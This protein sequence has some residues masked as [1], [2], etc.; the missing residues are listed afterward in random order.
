MSRNNVLIVTDCEADND[1]L[2]ELHPAVPP[3]LFPKVHP[4]QS[5]N[6][7]TRMPNDS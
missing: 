7:G 2:V 3:T 4:T 6:R 1:L 5:T